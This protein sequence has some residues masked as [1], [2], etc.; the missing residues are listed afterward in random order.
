V[1]PYRDLNY[2]DAV[3]RAR[4]AGAWKDPVVTI[5]LPDADRDERI[6]STVAREKAYG[7]IVASRRT[8]GVDVSQDESDK[9]RDELELPRVPLLQTK[10]AAPI[11]QWEIEQKVAAVD[12]ARERKGL[13]PLPN[14][15]GSVK[16]LAED[17]AKGIDKTGQ[18][19]VT[20]DKPEDVEEN[21]PPAQ[22]NPPVGD[23][24]PTGDNG[25]KTQPS[26]KPQKEG[27]DT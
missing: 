21:G 3:A 1:A 2:G 20:E 16:R 27:N 19:K 25:P 6:A 8:N 22:R 23:A 14:E 7:D 5:P 15:Q 11:E 26:G 12:E 13:A 24:K 10:N 9:L 4:K 17:R 18:T